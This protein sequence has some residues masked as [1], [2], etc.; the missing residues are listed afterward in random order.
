MDPLIEHPA[1]SM[2]SPAFLGRERCVRRFTAFALCASLPSDAVK[3]AS[4]RSAICTYPSCPPYFWSQLL[5]KADRLKHI[6]GERTT[7]LPC[8]EMECMIRSRDRKSAS[9][10]TTRTKSRKEVISRIRHSMYC[11][12][13]SAPSPSLEVSCKFSRPMRSKVVDLRTDPGSW[14][15]KQLS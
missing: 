6:R 10:P 12:K 11:G 1:G 8:T 5:A 14:C 7:I 15:S 9:S 4:I 3:Y 13:N 2:D